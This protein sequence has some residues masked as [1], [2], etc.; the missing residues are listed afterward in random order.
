VVGAVDV[1][2]SDFGQHKIVLSRYMPTGRVY[3]IDPDY[4]GIGIL[5]NFKVEQLAKVGDGNRGM[6]IAEMTTLVMNPDAHAQVL[7]LSAS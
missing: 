5:D 2:I 4:V 1:Y 7:G 3:C 6:I